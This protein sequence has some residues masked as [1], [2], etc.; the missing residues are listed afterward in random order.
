MGTFFLL[1]I[2]LVGYLMRGNF[3]SDFFPSYLFT[4][5]IPNPLPVTN[6]GTLFFE[7]LT[8]LALSNR[9]RGSRRGRRR[10]GGLD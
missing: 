2:I 8:I 4:L 9:R 10:F 1:L 5:S 7:W 6:I 3:L